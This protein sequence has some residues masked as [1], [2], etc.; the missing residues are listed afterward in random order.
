MDNKEQ[1]HYYSEYTVSTAIPDK[2]YRTTDTTHSIRATYTLSNGSEDWDPLDNPY[3]TGLNWKNTKILSNIRISIDQRSK[4][5]R[6]GWS[7]SLNYTT[8]A[9]FSNFQYN[10]INWSL[11][12][13]NT[14]IPRSDTTHTDD[15]IDCCIIEV[16]L[17]S[18]E[19]VNKGTHE[20]SDT[21]LLEDTEVGQLTIQEIVRNINATKIIAHERFKPHS[22]RNLIKNG[23]ESTIGN[24]PYI[25]RTYDYENKLEREE[26]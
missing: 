9:F 8:E 22:T 13:P 14:R 10:Y 19:E 6:E 23:T 25:F 1:I 3:G 17:K 11:L 15:L 24:L 12:W 2:K 16:D 7:P 26:R 21:I 4:E 18:V 5:Y 20:T